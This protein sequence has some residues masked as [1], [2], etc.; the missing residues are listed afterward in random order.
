MGDGDGDGDV[1]STDYGFWTGEFSTD[2]TNWPAEPGLITVSTPSDE[3]DGNYSYGNLSLREATSIASA[4]SG[5]DTIVFA[6]SVTGIELTLGEL[7][8]TSDVTIEGS[9]M[10]NLTIDALGNSR[11]FALAGGNTATLRGLTI[12]G[13][14]DVNDGAGV[15]AL[16]DLS[17]DS[18]RV[19]G[20]SS[21][22]YGGGIYAAGN[23]TIDSS[24][25]TDNDTV[26]D[27]G[28][29]FITTTAYTTIHGSTIDGNEAYYGSGIFAGISDGERLIIDSST[30]SN[31][32]GVGTYSAGG[33]VMIMGG[34]DDAVAT[35]IN[36][37]DLSNTA[38]YGG[39]LR[40]DYS[41]AYY[42]IINSTVAFNRADYTGGLE[43]SQGSTATLHNTIVAENTNLAGTSDSDIWQTLDSASSN[44]LLGRGGSG[45]L[46]NGTNGNI[47]L[48]T[49]QTAD[50]A[51]LGYYGGQTM[52]HALLSGSPA[53]AAGSESMA[54]AMG[55][56]SDQ[57]G[58]D[59]VE[60]VDIGAV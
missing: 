54:A 37:T 38:K 12:T 25:I 7:S 40:A 52:T 1:D 17:L 11:V 20:N 10:N 19:D 23:L 39:G 51:A 60:A 3:S 9:G 28:G 36:S 15:Y 50:L 16:G 53:I 18:V 42:N 22:R 5:M 41:T 4:N 34:D 21:T 27:G 45:G 2:F 43:L 35:I 55:L 56:S 57:R 14:G 6:P 58:F 33:G 30:I 59:R 29:I 44:N 8:I 48:T 31:N 32:H 49:G 26:W 13:G 47:V 24:L 46:S